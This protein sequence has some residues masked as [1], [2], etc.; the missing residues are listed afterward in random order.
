[1]EAGKARGDC[2][3]TACVLR[4]VLASVGHTPAL[5]LLRP[6]PAPLPA[7]CSD[8]LNRDDGRWYNFNDSSVSPSSA[9]R[10]S[11]SAAYLLFYV[12]RRAFPAPGVTLRAGGGGGGAGAY[13]GEDDA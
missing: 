6:T 10:L 9:G 13:E 5:L 2:S 12:R 4:G 8:C 1:M 3:V 7:C 11:K